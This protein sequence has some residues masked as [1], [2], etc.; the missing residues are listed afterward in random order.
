MHYRINYTWIFFSNTT[1]PELR[2][3]KASFGKVEF[4]RALITRSQGVCVGQ[5][6]RGRCEVIP[7]GLQL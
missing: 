2:N 1:L 5:D 7:V 6:T 4:L 3:F